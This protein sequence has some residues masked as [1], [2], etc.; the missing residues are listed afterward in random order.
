MMYEYAA[1]VI[2]VYDGD[3]F[4][5]DVDL[6]FRVTCRGLDFRMLGINAPEVRGETRAA[7]LASRD[8]LRHLVL[9]LDVTIHTHLDEQEK[10][11]RWLAQVFVSGPDAPMLDVN[12]WLVDN[13]FALPYMVVK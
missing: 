10:Y 4:R 8:A 5:A 12:K 11:G 3:T 9:D 6:G 1:H 7:G 2:S 13:Q